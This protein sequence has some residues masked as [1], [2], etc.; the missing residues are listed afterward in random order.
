TTPRV[1]QESHRHDGS[2]RSLPGAPP[3]PPLPPP[4]LPP[5][6]GPRSARRPGPLGPAPP[7]RGRWGPAAHDAPPQHTARHAHPFPRSRPLVNGIGGTERRVAIYGGGELGAPARVACLC[8]DV[9]RGGGTPTSQDR[10]RAALA[11]PPD[12]PSA[13]RIPFGGPP[14]PLP[15]AADPLRGRRLRPF[16]SRRVPRRAGRRMSLARRGHRR[17]SGSPSS[18]RGGAPPACRGP[19][20]PAPA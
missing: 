16:Q 9:N 3:P 20:A 18:P 17:G 4:P 2:P 5:P 7:R 13:P 14:A 1:P 10:V 12:S 11:M 19:A 6:A 8:G 15:R